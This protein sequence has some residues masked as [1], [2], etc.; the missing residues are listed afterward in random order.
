MGLELVGILE[1]EFNRLYEDSDVIKI[2]T[3][4]RNIRFIAELTKFGVS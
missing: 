3:K 2:E 1:Q 4:I